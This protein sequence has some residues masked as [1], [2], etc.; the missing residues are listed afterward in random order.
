MQAL[1]TSVF[2]LFITFAGNE[3]M[4][5]DEMLKLAKNKLFQGSEIYS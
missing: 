1:L 2:S 4:E 5:N 3:S